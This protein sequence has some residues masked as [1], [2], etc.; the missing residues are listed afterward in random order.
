MT[1]EVPTR[2]IDNKTTI[3]STNTP[4]FDAPIVQERDFDYDDLEGVI[5]DLDNPYDQTI[6]VT[7]VMPDTK[8]KSIQKEHKVTTI[9]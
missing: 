4:I 9:A 2:T 1:L 8:A 3:Y 6:P 5:D 7:V